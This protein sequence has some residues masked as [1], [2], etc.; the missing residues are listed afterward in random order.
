[1]NS[2]T[3]NNGRKDKDAFRKMFELTLV[4]NRNFTVA[5]YFCSRREHP[6]IIHNKHEFLFGM[7]LH[8]LLPFFI[9]VIDDSTHSYSSGKPQN[10]SF[11][12]QIKE[13]NN[14]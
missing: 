11:V 13:E 8:I 5:S 3:T 1:M 4:L 10:C 9:R 7:L 14:F 6:C 12:L 2:L